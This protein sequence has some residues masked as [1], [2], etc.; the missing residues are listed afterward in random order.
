MPITASTALS[1]VRLAAVAVEQGELEPVDD[2][3]V[4]P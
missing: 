1:G 2:D 3:E 4:V